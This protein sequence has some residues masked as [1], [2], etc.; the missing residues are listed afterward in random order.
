MYTFVFTYK[1]PLPYELSLLVLRFS[2]HVRI[3]SKSISWI[4]FS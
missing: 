1:I 2:G 4:M 3:G